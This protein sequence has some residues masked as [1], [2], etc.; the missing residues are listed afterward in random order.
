MT[1]GKKI[2]DL[3]KSKGISQELLAE[4]SRVSLRTIQRI[5]NGS[6]TPR[7]F[8][9]KLIADCLGVAVADLHSPANPAQASAEALNALRLINM[10]CLT[11]LMVP[12]L[13]IILPALV[14]RRNLQHLPSSKAAKKIISVQILW[15]AATCAILVIYQLL[16]MWLTGSV[17]VGRVPMLAGVYYILVL[18]DV[19]IIIK[20]ARDLDRGREMFPKIPT[21]F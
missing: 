12:F 5:E 8:T 17:V 10:S 1:P 2:S 18:V 3:R 13:N 14:W 7:L 15:T 20:T 19:G 9:L 11:I 16:Q 4:N 21:L 6:S